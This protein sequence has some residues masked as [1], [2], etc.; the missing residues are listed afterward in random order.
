MLYLKL[1][2]KIKFLEL[3]M[4]LGHN[5]LIRSEFVDCYLD[6]NQPHDIVV[7]NSSELFDCCQLLKTTH[8]TLPQYSYAISG[9]RRKYPV[10]VSGVFSERDWRLLYEDCGYSIQNTHNWVTSLIQINEGNL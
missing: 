7:N 6:K 3:R 5:P 1:P 10:E 9:I 2:I 4:T 8:L